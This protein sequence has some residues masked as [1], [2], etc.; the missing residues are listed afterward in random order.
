MGGGEEVRGGQEA[1][2]AAAELGGDEGGV[3]DVGDDVV[4][5]E[6]DVGFFRRVDEV[7]AEVALLEGPEVAF[8]VGAVVLVGARV[9]AADRVFLFDDGEEGGVVACVDG[10]GE[11]VV[12]VL[13]EDGSRDVVF[14]DHGRHGVDDISGLLLGVEEFEFAA[15]V[16]S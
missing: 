8:G 12:G 6:G 2:A 11:V 4:V 3:R 14:L 9:G 1:V 16:G 10:V 13:D 5:G 15:F 7:G